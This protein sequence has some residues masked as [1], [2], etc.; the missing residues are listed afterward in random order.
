[1]IFHNR[2]AE[3]SAIGEQWTSSGARLLLLYGRR[4]V[5][6]TFLL[7]H[8]LGQDKPHCYFLSAQTSLSENLAELARAVVTSTSADGL[9][10]A[11]LPTFNGILHFMDQAA[12]DR[13]F[14]LVL[15]EFQYLL[16]LDSSIPSQI[17]AWWDTTGI[18]GNT[19]LVLCGSHLGIMEG[20]G[21]SQAPLFG[22][23]TFRHKL[24][25]M[26]YRDIA[27]FYAEGAY[28]TRDK[29]TAYGVLGGTPRYHALFGPTQDLGQSIRTHILS[30]L[31]L[32]HNEPEVLMSS[33][34]IRD[35]FPYN[36]TLRAIADGCT[37]PAELAQR[38]G[39]SPA[40]MSF[41]LRSLMDLEWVTREYPFGE[42]SDRRAVYKIADPFIR[43]WY[44]FVAGLRSELEFQ[45]TDAVFA[46]RVQPHM[47]DY[48][49]IHA[50]EEICHQYLRHDGSRIVGQPIRRAGRYW[51]RDGQLELD[52]MAEMDDGR[53][54]LGE[55]KWSS[56][57]VGVGVYYQLRDKVAGLPEAKYRDKPVFIILSAAGFK[58]ELVQ[59]AG[60]DG[61]LLV[62]G[63]DLLA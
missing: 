59:M 10:P 33:S 20:L 36:S 52:I 45:A 7:Q 3:L 31:G 53:F 47:N 2:T 18:R 60:R 28:S 57:P 17:Q 32:L 58:D 35:P 50:F 43:F 21:G 41:Y 9:T 8:F 27:Q 63:D 49:G 51:S 25:P 34:R 23:F 48:M 14:A 13:R 19:F 29:L 11:D 61:V 26:T 30:P 4:R 38:V 22:R 44:R 54:L 42:T 1:M 39:V 12:R 40:Q 62:S 24:L 5:G 6:K 37:R 46:S 55:C 15:D 56:S 16:D